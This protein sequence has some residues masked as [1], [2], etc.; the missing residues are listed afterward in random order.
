MVAS[1]GE[2]ADHS[3]VD[4]A[5]RENEADETVPGE[6]VHAILD[7][8]PPLRAWRQHRRLTL[9][10]LAARVGVSKGCLSQ[11]EN[12]R[13]SGTVDH[14]RRVAAALDVTLEDLGG[15]RDA[16]RAGP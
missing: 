14:A 2:S 13:R 1:L 11:I 10:E 6:V 4:R 5:L 15:L 3:A 8:T 16:E 7:G 12:G 9:D